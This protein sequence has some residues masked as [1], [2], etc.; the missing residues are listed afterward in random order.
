MIIRCVDLLRR[1]KI[2]FLPTRCRGFCLVVELG[3]QGGAKTPCWPPSPLRFQPDPSARRAILQNGRL[4]HFSPTNRTRLD[5]AIGKQSTLSLH[6]TRSLSSRTMGHPSTA[7]SEV[8]FDRTFMMSVSTDDG[9]A[10]GAFGASQA[11]YQH[12]QAIPNG[13]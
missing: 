13:Y 4:S 3:R 10:R 12:D 6:A 7:W 5:S 11:P 1:T 8:H 2:I 9:A